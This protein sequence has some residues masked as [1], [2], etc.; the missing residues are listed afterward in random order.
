MQKSLSIY[1]FKENETIAS[2]G[3][4]SGVWEIWFASQVENLTFYLQDIDEQNCNE[5]EIAYGVKYYENLLQKPISG[6]FIPIIGTPH[7]TNLPSDTFDKVLIINSLHEF[8]FPL[9]ILRDI[10]RILRKEGTLF[11]E[12]QLA[13]FQGEIHEGCGKRLFTQHELID[14]LQKSGFQLK[15]TFPKHSNVWIFK[16]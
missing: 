1:Q 4:S 13:N 11:I 15:E 12:E 2:I 6:K 9:F 8:Q 5:E 7:Q 3:A 10:Q 16:F 14:L